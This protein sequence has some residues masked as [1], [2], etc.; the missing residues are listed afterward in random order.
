MFVQEWE[1]DFIRRVQIRMNEA[2]SNK[3]EY[4]TGTEET[5]KVANVFVTR[6]SKSIAKSSRNEFFLPKLT[7]STA[8]P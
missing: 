5:R 2:I 3:H 6:G 4:P 7:F 1:C 8:S